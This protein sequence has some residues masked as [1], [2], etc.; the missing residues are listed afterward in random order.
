MPESVRG[1]ARFRQRGPGLCGYGGSLAD[2]VAK[3]ESCQWS[4]GRIYEEGTFLRQADGTILQCGAD[5]RDCF[6]PEW[7]E[8]LLAALAEQPNLRRRFEA[9]RREAEVNDFLGSCPSVGH[10][11]KQRDIAAAQSRGSINT[12]E[13]MLDVRASEARDWPEWRSLV[14][15]GE[16]LLA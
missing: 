1:Y 14:R 9:N 5:K 6:W 15:D 4:T 7:A 16:H 2:Y 11:L 13:Q 12:G 8:A 3:P 10:E